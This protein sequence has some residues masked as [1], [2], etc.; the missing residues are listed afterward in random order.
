MKPSKF[1]TPNKETMF[2]LDWYFGLDLN[3]NVR[4]HEVRNW[5]FCRIADRPF[6]HR[7]RRFK[8]W[9]HNRRCQ[10]KDR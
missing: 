5:Y 10:W 6:H 2:I 1:N 4:H 7:S 3:E 9:K 8:T